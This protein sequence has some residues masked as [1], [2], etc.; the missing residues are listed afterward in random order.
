[1]KL[2]EYIGQSEIM[3]CGHTLTVEGIITKPIDKGK[4]I[5]R[6]LVGSWEDGTPSRPFKAS[7]FTRKRIGYISKQERIKSRIGETSTAL[8]GMKMTVIGYR[9]VNDIDVKFEDGTVV[10]HKGYREF[11]NG[12]IKNPSLQKRIYKS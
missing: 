2:E 4:R 12:K 8:C 6:L 3:A 10:E 11:K 9:T 1:M 7:D 5:G